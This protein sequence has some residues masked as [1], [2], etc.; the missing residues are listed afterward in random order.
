MEA[1]WAKCA[2]TSLFKK[3]NGYRKKQNPLYLMWT[4][5]SGV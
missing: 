1:R 4:S 3:K 5:V 2:Y